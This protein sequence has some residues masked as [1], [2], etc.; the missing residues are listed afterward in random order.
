M[1][2]G[3]GI[4]SGRVQRRQELERRLRREHGPS[5]TKSHS[6]MRQYNAFQATMP[7]GDVDRGYF[8]K[9]MDKF[10]CP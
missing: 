9:L 10:F 2:G 3:D 4:E 1:Y 8:Q 7:N 5:W 6:A